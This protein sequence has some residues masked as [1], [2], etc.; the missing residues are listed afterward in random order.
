MDGIRDMLVAG[1]ATQVPG[2]G[3]AD[4]VEFSRFNDSYDVLH[5]SFLL[6]NVMKTLRIYQDPCRFA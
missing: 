6:S 2:K 4:L 5:G 3:F 1:A